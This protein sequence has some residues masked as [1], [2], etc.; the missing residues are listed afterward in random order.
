MARVTFQNRDGEKIFEPLVIDTDCI[1]TAKTRVTRYMAKEHNASP[2]SVEYNWENKW[3]H[4]YRTKHKRVYYAGK[5]SIMI[6]LDLR[7]EDVIDAEFEKHAE[8]RAEAKRDEQLQMES[9]FEKIKT[10][11][12][13]M[14]KE[15]TPDAN[16]EDTVEKATDMA[17][18]ILFEVHRCHFTI[19]RLAKEYNNK[20]L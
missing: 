15:F 19:G 4:L 16:K 3:N 8:I 18:K 5:D 7:T 9:N 13:K 2:K 6:I 1:T 17:L 10:A 14:N 12:S 11:L 20:H